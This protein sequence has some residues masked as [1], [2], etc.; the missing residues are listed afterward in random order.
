MAKRSVRESRAQVDATIRSMEQTGTAA[1]I[2]VTPY[3][4]NCDRG[5]DGDCV[6]HHVYSVEEA[7][8]VAAE[9]E[10]G[11]GAATLNPF[12]VFARPSFPNLFGTGVDFEV[13]GLWGFD[14]GSELGDLCAGQDCYER[15]VSA[16]IVRPHVFGTRADA[17]ITG[18]F[19][20]RTTPARGRIDS[21]LLDARLSWRVGEHWNVYTGYL[22][23]LANISKD[24]V[25]PLGGTGGATP[26]ID[27]SEAIVS[28]LTGL[29]QVGA[30]W[31]RADNAFNPNKGFLATFDARIASPFLGGRDWWVMV[32]GAWQ[33]FIPIPATG[34]RLQV[35]YSLS[36]GHAVPFQ[37]PLAPTTSI[38][39]VW[40]YY[41]GGTAALGL[42]GILPET[43]VLDIEEVPLP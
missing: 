24:L 43:M 13:Q 36:Y 7:K 41:G 8:D 40:R 1:G 29:L 26:Y 9:V 20:R 6:V 21:A 11:F 25:K 33:H 39:E 30:A 23:Q 35:R 22:F 15:T 31:D 19:Q 37:G 2:Q 32:N 10:Y 3:P 4:V 27:R 28:D 16:A 12:Y 18:Q 34:D 14:V 5:T 17:G 38:P 42:R